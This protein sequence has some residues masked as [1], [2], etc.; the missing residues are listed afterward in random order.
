MSPH[1]QV[2]ESKIVSRVNLFMYNTNTKCIFYVH[3]FSP[4]TKAA[5]HM[6]LSDDLKTVIHVAKGRVSRETQSVKARVR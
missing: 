4:S 2:F 1:I 5:T 6:L 3:L